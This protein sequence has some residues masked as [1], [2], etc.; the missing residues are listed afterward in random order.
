MTNGS[1]NEL[2]S[3]GPQ[4]LAKYNPNCVKLNRSYTFDELAALLDVHKNTVANWTKNGLPYLSERRPF[5][6][7]GADARV[8]LRQQREA[9]KRQCKADEFFCMRCKGPTKPA[10]NFLEYVPMSDTKGRLI[11]LCR[12]CEGIVNK[13]VGIGSLKEYSAVFDLTFPTGSEH[14]DDCDHRLLNSDL[15]K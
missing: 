6:I 4:P 2:S 1:P 5:L 8:Y 13:F 11:G 10:E 12:F 3:V 15:N 9:K 7:L 14:I